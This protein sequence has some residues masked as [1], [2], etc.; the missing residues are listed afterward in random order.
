MILFRPCLCHL[1]GAIP[2][3]SASSRSF[4]QEAAVSCVS[5]AQTLLALLPNQAVNSHA[6]KILPWWSLLHYITQAGAVLILELCLKAEHM[7]SQ[8]NELLGDVR[9]VMVWLAEMAADSPSAWRSWK[10]FR[11]LSLQAAAVVGIEVVIPDDVQKPPEWPATHDQRLSQ[12]L[13]VASDQSSSLQTLSHLHR[14]AGLVPAAEIPNALFATNEEVPGTTWPVLSSMSNPTG[15]PAFDHR[16]VYLSPT[17][18]PAAK[19]DW[20]A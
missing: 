11:K 8:V 10:I 9:K 7:P 3:E 5:A 1:E 14:Q 13:D 12:T 18:D 20:E 4:N 16:H 6:S 17:G 2:H 15:N 19:M